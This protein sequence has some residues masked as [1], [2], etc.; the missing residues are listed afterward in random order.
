M[1]D[2]FI[3]LVDFS[4]YS[5]DLL[6]FAY[7]WSKRIDA[8]I[9]LVHSTEVL[10]PVMAPQESKIRLTALA[11]LDA[12]EKLKKCAEAVLPEGTSAKPLV[13]EKPLVFLLRQLL[14][15]HYN[16]LVFLGIKGTGL[17][18]KIFIGTQAVKV[19]DGIDNLIV[20]VPQN[21]ACCSPESIHVSVLKN[22][23]LNIFEFNKFLNFTGEGIKRIVF[24]S[25]IAS[26][27]ERDSTEKYLKE[28]AELYSDKRDVSY[29]LYQGDVALP[30]LKNL[31][32]ERHNE[33]IVIQRGSR[34]FLDQVFRKFL[35]N[36]LVYEG[37]TPLIILP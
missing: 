16:H 29:E 1:R 33:F 22:Y 10:L 15:K 18:K 24:F 12:L 13:S 8:E 21:A 31:I 6:R 30:G 5:K 26:N 9:L 28:L 25:F 2:R 3:V 32:L 14:Q 34:M 20:A 17:L 7:D 37:R 19:I 27:N 11:N 23:P 35:I 36:E 4:V